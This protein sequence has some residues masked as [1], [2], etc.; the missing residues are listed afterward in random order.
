MGR[1]SSGHC[2]GRAHGEV[3]LG[4]HRTCGHSWMVAHN[5]PKGQ[6]ERGEVR[7]TSGEGWSP[8]GS[9]AT[10]LDLPLSGS[11]RSL[12]PAWGKPGDLICSVLEKPPAFTVCSSGTSRGPVQPKKTHQCLAMPVADTHLPGHRLQIYLTASL[13]IRQPWR[14]LGHGGGRTGEAR[15]TAPSTWNIFPQSK[16]AC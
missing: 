8:C 5:P 14:G 3:T 1:R 9:R 4:P 2:N 11:G 10:R 15:S 12:E 7:S 16:E 6:R 13:G